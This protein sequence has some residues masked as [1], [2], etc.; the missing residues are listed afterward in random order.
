MPGT[1]RAAR[2]H[3]KATREVRWSANKA[4]NGCSMA[5]SAGEKAVLKQISREYMPTSSHFCRGS[6]RILEVSI[7]DVYCVAFYLDFVI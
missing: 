5:S 2:T 6:S 4:T 7:Y 3:A 1:P